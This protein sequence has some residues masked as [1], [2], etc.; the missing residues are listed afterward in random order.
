MV[1]ILSNGAGGVFKYDPHTQ[2]LSPVRL[3]AGV[4]PDGGSPDR[5]F[6][7]SE[8]SLWLSY[9]NLLYRV[10][11]DRKRYERYSHEPGNP[12]SLTGGTVSAMCEDHSGRIWV[13]TDR[14]LNRFDRTARLFTRFVYD[15][16]YDSSLSN[17]NVSSLCV[18]HSGSLWVGTEDGLNRFNEEAESFSRFFPTSSL[19]SRSI[20]QIVEDRRGCLW[21][22]T[23][24][25]I[26]KLDCRLCALLRHDP[27]HGRARRC[28]RRRSLQVP[29]LLRRQDRR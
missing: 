1:W 5:L 29:G 3:P 7:D 22:T 2:A 24:A 27:H 21:L 12:H 28:I 10:S 4:P 13:A 11:P 23:N 19:A 14:G 6:V 20:G 25:G 18:D 9:G 26:V 8:K 15:P 17:N 16:N